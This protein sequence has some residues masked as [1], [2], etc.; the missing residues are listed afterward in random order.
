MLENL[1]SYLQE[2]SRY[3]P[4]KEGGDEIIA[5]IRNHILEKAERQSG[6]ATEESVRTV[7]ASYGRP[8][9]VASPYVEGS[10]I[11]APVFRRHLF[12]Y[13]WMLFAVHAALTALAIGLDVDIVMFP[14][15]L[16]PRMPTA[17]ALL[18]LPMAWLADFGLVAF[19]LFIV[20]QKS[21]RPALPWLRIF[22]GRPLGR[23]KPSA[24]AWRLVL[25]AAALFL[26]IRHHTIFFYAVN[27]RPLESIMDPTSS[28][29]LSSM[30]IAAILC[31]VTA[32]AVRFVVN[33]AWVL[34]AKNL[35]VLLIMWS[36]WN[37]P[38]AVR[39]KEIPGVDLR[40]YAGAFV[41]IL[42]AWTAVRFLRSFFL[43]VREMSL[44]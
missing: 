27:V 42:I 43:V 13:T 24:L 20:T 28:V 18:Y 29:V 23:P 8:Q 25:L 11:I 19:V 4:V 30:F 15:F 35:V 2:I 9:D 14:F 5:E 22:R 3:L 17:A 12:R 34:F 38:I 10:E 39:F 21:R 7:I 36:I 32:H 26:L 40:F 41:I 33:S 44:E 6:E 31:N 37:V 16:I 1:E